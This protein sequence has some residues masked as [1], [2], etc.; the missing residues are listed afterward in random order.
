MTL[1]CVAFSTQ[2]LSAAAE[3]IAARCRALQ[4]TIPETSTLPIA[5]ETILPLLADLAQQAP[6][7]VALREG[8]LVGFLLALVLPSFRGKRSVYSPEWANGAL[9]AEADTIYQALY[10]QLAAQWVADGCILHALT[11]LA[12][13]TH[14]LAGWYWQGFGLNGIDAVRNMDNVVSEAA[15]FT[16][17]RATLA[18][19]ELVAAHSLALQEHLARPPV[20]KSLEEP[21]GS[22]YYAQ[23]LA[24]TDH[25]MW[26]AYD[27][28]GI[29]IGSLGLV[30]ANADTRLLMQDPGTLNI[31]HA[32]TEP[33]W[34]GH[35]I[36]AALLAQAI[37]AGRAQGYVRCAVDFESP[38]ITAARFW[39]R[40]FR[41]VCYSVIRVVS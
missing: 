21:D 20:F 39:I 27:D 16:I 8:Q 24:E 10:A 37:S 35:G 6:G 12:N 3:L 18:D 25:V 19:L 7:L 32:Y 4:T 14:G 5:A 26:L 29:P 23:W 36:A 15:P 2:H 31:M 1:T 30:P 9:L 13:D 33:A 22:D 38:N 34:R 40:H 41:P 28:N 17:R 11:V